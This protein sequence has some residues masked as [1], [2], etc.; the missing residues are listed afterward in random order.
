MNES[1]S[2]FLIMVPNHLWFTAR[3][4]L[5]VPLTVGGS[6][7]VVK[8]LSD[9]DIM[10]TQNP[11]LKVWKDK[12]AVFRV[13]GSVRP[14]IR[15]EE[16]PLVLKAIAEDSELEFKE[17]KHQYGVDTWRNVGYGFWQHACLAQIVKL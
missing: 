7:N 14:F 15:Q 11:R 4:A 1:A 13:D 5:S 16:K 8:V 2:K 3:A 10:V 12:F 17:D 6:T 9:L